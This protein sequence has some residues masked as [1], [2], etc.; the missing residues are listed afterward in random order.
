[1]LIFLFPLLICLRS[2]VILAK[3]CKVDLRSSSRTCLTPNRSGFWKLFVWAKI[4]SS[5][6]NAP[7]AS[8]EDSTSRIFPVP[9][10]VCCPIRKFAEQDLSP[11]VILETACER[12][13]D[14]RTSEHLTWNGFRSLSQS[15]LL[16]INPLIASPTPSEF[17]PIFPPTTPASVKQRTLGPLVGRIFRKSPSTWGI[18]SQF[19]AISK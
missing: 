6:E 14:P 17:K 3:R 18:Q 7:V 11:R 1:M 16:E 15:S 19:W 12:V 10:F 8:G 9:N 13:F 2:W 5:G 4:P